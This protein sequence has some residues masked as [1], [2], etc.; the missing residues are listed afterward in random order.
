ML[1]NN[2]KTHKTN[3][4]TRTKNQIKKN[5]SKTKANRNQTTKALQRD[6][7]RIKHESNI[8]KGC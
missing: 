3:E 6:Y 1:K 4:Q 5:I 2:K 8:Y 7:R